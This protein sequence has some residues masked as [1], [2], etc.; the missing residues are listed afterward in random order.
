M[1]VSAAGVAVGGVAV[2][3]VAGG[4]VAEVAGL[5][6][7]FSGGREGDER[8][9]AAASGGGLPKRRDKGGN[10]AAR[11]TGVLSGVSLGDNG[12]VVDGASAKE[13][14]TFEPPVINFGAPNL[15][16]GIGEVTEVGDGLA[17]VA[18]IA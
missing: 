7:T 17:V 9:G 13:D 5:V 1:F 3:E 6:G 11:L 12:G 18:G 14:S 8:A 16:V 2:G 4:G 15:A 10:G